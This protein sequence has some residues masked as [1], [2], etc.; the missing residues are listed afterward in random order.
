VRKGD[1]KA[2][3]AEL[4]IALQLDPQ[5]PDAGPL[6]HDLLAAQSQP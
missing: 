5:Y 1:S 4:E 2:A 3:I 6:L